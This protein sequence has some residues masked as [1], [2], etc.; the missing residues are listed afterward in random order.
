MIQRASRETNLGA[1]RAG[2]MIRRASRC[3]A[4]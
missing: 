1:K 4:P 3:A 2:L